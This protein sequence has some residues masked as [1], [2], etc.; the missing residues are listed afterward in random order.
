[1]RFRRGLIWFSDHCIFYQTDFFLG[2]CWRKWGFW[3]SVEIDGF[4]RDFC[5][6]L[7]IFRF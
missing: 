5:L 2:S 7:L 4:V 3:V 6:S 1:V